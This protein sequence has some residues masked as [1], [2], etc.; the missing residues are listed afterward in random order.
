[1]TTETQTT[2]LV[3]SDGV[4]DICRNE[5]VET[6]LAPDNIATDDDIVAY[7]FEDQTEALLAEHGWTI[8]RWR[9]ESVATAA[10]YARVVDIK[11]I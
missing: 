3:Y 10:G 1:M 4:V 6:T 9:R 8:T 7:A 11:P 5:M 2:A